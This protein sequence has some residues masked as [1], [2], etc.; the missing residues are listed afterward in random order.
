MRYALYRLMAQGLRRCQ[1]LT[2]TSTLS[3]GGF[4]QQARVFFN[5]LPLWPAEPGKLSTVHPGGYYRA[6][7]PTT[8]ALK[9][10]HEVDGDGA[11]ETA[12]FW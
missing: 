4:T 12:A 3:V 5:G 10:I 9:W 2:S 7:E 8:G 11:Y 6:I 1:G